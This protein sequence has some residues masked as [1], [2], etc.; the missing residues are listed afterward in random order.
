VRPHVDDFVLIAL[1]DDLRGA[2]GN[3]SAQPRQKF[4]EIGVLAF[5]NMARVGQ[6]KLDRNFLGTLL[7]HVHDLAHKRDE[8]SS[9]AV[10]ARID[11]QVHRSAQIPQPFQNFELTG[12][13]F[14]GVKA[15]FSLALEFNR[16]PVGGLAQHLSA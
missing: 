2:L 3:R 14:A 10:R 5:K 15:G 9:N 7:R 13:S 4:G 12:A 6:L 11:L 8:Q 16:N 1:S